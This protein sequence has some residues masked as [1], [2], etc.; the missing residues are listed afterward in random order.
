MR[1][2]TIQPEARWNELQETGSL[3]TTHEFVEEYF[4]TP[5]R[6]MISQMRIRLVD[7]PAEDTRSPLWAWYQYSSATRRMPDLRRSAHLAR[8]ERGVRIELEVDDSRVLLSDFNLWHSCLN[9][10]HLPLSRRDS[11]AW[12]RKLKLHGVSEFWSYENLPPQFRAEVEQSW[13]RIFDF[14]WRSRYVGATPQ[15]E[16]A[17]QATLW[18]IRKEDVR[19]MVR[20]VAR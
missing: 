11:D 12:D 4:L 13:E 16:R 10:W 9:G 15:R 7:Q 5:Y 6:W 3:I 20:F 17:I 19:K 8:Y 2:W 18:E 14:K 1:L